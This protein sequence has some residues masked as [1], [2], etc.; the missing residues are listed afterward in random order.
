MTPPEDQRLALA[1][2]ID[3]FAFP[4]CDATF[5]TI[6]CRM[7]RYEA[8]AKAD[9]CIAALRAT[10]VRAALERA[11]PYVRPSHAGDVQADADL[12]AID[13]ALAAIPHEREGK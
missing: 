10:D 11:R 2:I 7:E 12:R 4:S 13:T 8:L 9:E 1:K 6:E 5:E 3:P